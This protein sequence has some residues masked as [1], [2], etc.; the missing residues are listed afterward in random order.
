MMCWGT[1]LSA[2]SFS[3]LKAV[4]IAFNSSNKCSLRSCSYLYLGGTSMKLT[5]SFPCLIFYISSATSLYYSCNSDSF[6][7]AYANS[8]LLFLRVFEK[9]LFSFSFLLIFYLISASSFSRL[10]FIYWFPASS[11]LRS[12]F[13]LSIS[14]VFCSFKFS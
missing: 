2:Y 4:W 10:F 13:Y 3:F 12:D 5:F 9:L 6:L 7:E 1:S 11:S 8:S 14:L